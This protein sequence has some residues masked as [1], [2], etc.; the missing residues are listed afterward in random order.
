[1]A[2]DFKLWV[3]LLVDWVIDQLV[4]GWLEVVST[5]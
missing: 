1:M 3:V 5:E 2:I 4:P